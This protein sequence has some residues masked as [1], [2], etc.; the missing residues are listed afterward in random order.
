MIFKGEMPNY[1]VEYEEDNLF[2]TAHPTPGF[3]L[4]NAWISVRYFK[5]PNSANTF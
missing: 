3:Y 4:V 2:V 1:I 5:H